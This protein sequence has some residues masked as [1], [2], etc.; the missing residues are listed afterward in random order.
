MRSPGPDEPSHDGPPLTE[1]ASRSELD[2]VRRVYRAYDDDPRYRRL[3]GDGPGHRFILDRKWDL[4]ARS[5]TRVGL[6]PRGARV[7]DLGCGDRGDSSRFCS[8]GAPAWGIVALDLSPVYATR[9]RDSNPG[10]RALAGN[11][12]SLPFRDGAFDIVYQSTL[13]SSLLDPA[14]RR[15]VLVEAARVLDRGGVFLSYDVRYRNPWNPHTRPV[16]SVDLRGAFAGW[17]L[18]TSTATG[19]PQL[20]RRLAPLSIGA[21]RLIETIPLLRTHLVVAA[22][23]P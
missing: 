15:A 22:R 17:S 13:L 14:L 6:D 21:C 20:I 9:T 12:A 7:L 2:R 19:I 16:R 10:T 4:I 23:K 5:L 3:W 18:T 11:A 1:G 8:L